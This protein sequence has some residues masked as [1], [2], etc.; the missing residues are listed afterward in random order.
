[1]D[2]QDRRAR[3]ATASG[4]RKRSSNGSRYK[5]PYIHP[6]HLKSEHLAVCAEDLNEFID[7]YGDE[8]P[9]IVTN[10]QPT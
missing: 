8:G 9:D 1:M 6:E 7:H 2:D 5:Y 4:A 3:G 10:A